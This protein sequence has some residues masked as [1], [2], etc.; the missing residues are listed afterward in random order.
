MT[1]YKNIILGF[2]DSKYSR[3]ALVET[4]SWAKAHDSKV[5]IVHAVFFDSEEFSISPGQLE[6]RLCQGKAAC[7]KVVDDYSPEFG[8]DIEYLVIQGEPREVIT[9]VAREREADLIAMGTYGRKGLRRMIMGSVTSGVILYSPCDVLVVKKPCEEC[10]GHYRSVLVPYDG[11]N[12]SKRAIE[13]IVNI[14]NSDEPSMTMLYVIPRYEEMVGFFK[15]DAI[16]RSIQ[17][18][19]TRIVLEGEQIAAGNGLNANTMIEEGRAADKIVESA[20]ELGS[21]LIV[22]GSHGWH[23]MDKSI[24]GSTAERVIAHSP[25]PILIVR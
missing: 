11:S 3:A 20:R 18:E 5:T 7:K 16:E 25:I 21:D 19:A 4:L 15:T 1:T 9:R 10:S 24:L 22:I 2:D 13:R 6:D 17:E 14:T 23:G 8:V 12:P